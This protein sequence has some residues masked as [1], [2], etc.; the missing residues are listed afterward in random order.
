MEEEKCLNNCVG[1]IYNIKE[2]LLRVL[3][4]QFNKVWKIEKLRVAKIRVNIVLIFFPDEEVMEKIIKGGPWCFD[5][6]LL[7]L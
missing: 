4:M 3:R 5:N 2:Y 1:R 7:V 6:H